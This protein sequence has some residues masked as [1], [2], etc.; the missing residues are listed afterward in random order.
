M[1]VN[2]RRAVPLLILVLS[3]A[4]ACQDI[5]P[6]PTSFESS[7]DGKRG[8]LQVGGPYAGAEFHRS[9]PFPSRISFYYPVANSIDLSTDY[10][11]RYESMPFSSSLTIDGHTESLG[12]KPL[13][14]RSTPSHVVFEQDAGDHKTEIAYYFGESLPVMALRMTV[15]NQSSKVKDVVLVT[16]MKATLRT[17]HAYKLKNRA[18]TSYDDEDTFRAEFDDAE[19][20]L[21]SIFVA[22]AGHRP[23]RDD[24]VHH[25]ERVKQEGPE[26]VFTYHK[27]LRPGDDLV[28]V[29]IIGSCRRPESGPVVQRALD[30]WREDV[31][32]YERRV[33]DYAM[34]YSPFVLEDAALIRTERW[35]KALLQ[36]DKHYI[37][38]QVVPM[39]TPAQYNFFFTHDLQLTDLGAVLF[40]TDRVKRDLLYLKQRSEPDGVL[41]H[42]YY[43]RD[44][45]FKTEIANS[46]NWNHLWF[47][48]LTSSYYKH[49]ADKETVELLFPMIRNSL[50]IMLGNQHDGLMLAER[51]DW[52]DIG[53]VYGERAYLTTL[54]IRA[55]REYA[56]LSLELGH[57]DPLAREYLDLS[58]R[59][60]EQLV[61]RLW[62]DEAG[63]LLN[64]L[65]ETTLDRHYY[66]GSLLAAAFELLDP[67][68]SRTLLE[69]ARRELLDE[70]IGIRNAMPPDFHK[71]T[72]QY[73]FNGP[74]VGEPY[75]Y[76]NG[77]V[78]P[79]GNAWYVM[80]LLAN[81]Q[82][83]AA[84]DALLRYMTLDGIRNSPNGQ[85]AFFEC[86]NADP[87]SPAYG[88]IDKTT[89]LW[90][91]GW[92]L[93]SLYHVIGVRENEWNL[94]FDPHLP[95]DTEHAAYD[96]MI[97][98]AR[99]R[100]TWSG[101]G[102][103]FKRITLDGHRAHS[104][105]MVGPVSQVALE[106]GRPDAPYL[107]YASGI[108][109]RV[110]YDDAHRHLDV[111]L[112]GV[113]GQ[114][115]E[116]RVVTPTPP[117][118]VSVNRVEQRDGLSIIRMHG[119][120]VV[121][122]S[123]TLTSRTQLVS[124]EF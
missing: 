87:D 23:T 58:R 80:A 26:A 113:P 6:L 41:A 48:L 46:D 105:V 66:S 8:Q 39:P 31:A 78:W 37:D 22:N 119:A 79:Q 84:R 116:V 111:E 5:P 12:D 10:W 74:E 104:A 25:R 36:A 53:H 15:A 114:V 61:R 67:P 38:G 50:R 121:K 40:D 75:Q 77:G 100:V 57:E 33:T 81:D 43:W 27:K 47:V 45:G 76:M 52:W 98:G 49:S 59:M 69:T 4:A 65:D 106:R 91:G 94:S 102:R 19:A 89:F 54:T 42:A 101:N 34:T 3:A 32:K 110:V 117:R 90:A 71:L 109:R 95:T 21:P 99:G 123:W 63:Y 7:F 86:R 120:C 56:Y 9:R 107:A 88:R 72:D 112:H 20:D 55:L 68:T 85:P 18:W 96:L 83:D 17:S 14:Y 16:R 13:A 51:P 44:E 24:R 92:Y 118:R 35:S 124:F 1:R 73:Q 30:T 62:D 64:K 2:I 70:K 82:P 115:V 108:V 93:Y 122:I 11:H 28:V 29:Q 60:N 97:H 103:Y